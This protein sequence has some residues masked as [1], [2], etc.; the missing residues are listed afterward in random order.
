M[1]INFNNK[2][3]G[4]DKLEIFPVIS[5]RAS[6][7]NYFHPYREKPITEDN[8]DFYFRNQYARWKRVLDKFVDPAWNAIDIGACFGDTPLII[9]SHC[10]K[11]V[12]FEPGYKGIPLCRMN[13]ASNPD[14][15]IEFFDYGINDKSGSFEA[16]YDEDGYNGGVV[17][18][19][20]KIGKWKYSTHLNMKTFDEHFSA[21]S[22]EFKKDLKFIKIDT[23][24]SDCRV[25]ESFKDF[26]KG[27]GA[28]V[29]LEWW[30]QTHDEIQRLVDYLD[31]DI[32][33]AGTLNKL[34]NPI[35]T[36]SWRQEVLI[37]PK[38]T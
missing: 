21:Y 11:V 27:N 9:A 34:N 30:P 19:K 25:L 12:A 31:Y 37:T 38:C 36:N 32:Y 13:F 3:I 35:W 33:D 14:L 22:D 29:S 6:K 24:S 26:I 2:E 28:I 20:I 18:E 16:F 15:D 23:E 1:I 7:I 8:G 17:T 5:A 10:K 4:V